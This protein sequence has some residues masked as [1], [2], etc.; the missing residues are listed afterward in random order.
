M[1]RPS[2][3]DDRTCY[4]DPAS[5]EPVIGVSDFID[6]SFQPDLLGMDPRPHTRQSLFKWPGGKWYL[7]HQIIP[8][9]PRH[10]RKMVSPFL[11]AGHIELEMAADGVKVYGSDIYRPMVDLWHEIKLDP[12]GF[13]DELRDTLGG[14]PL[15]QERADRG[16]M[17][18][19]ELGKGASRREVSVALLA[20]T[21]L[22]FG[23][24]VG[25][26]KA[27]TPPYYAEGKRDW[28]INKFYDLR[29]RAFHI[30]NLIVS[31]AD[32]RFAL[33]IH[34]DL[35][36]YCDPPYITKSMLYGEKGEVHKAFDHAEFVRT[37]MARPGPWA[38]SYNDCEFVR[39]AF[40]GCRFVEVE[41]DYRI[42][43]QAGK[44]V[45]KTTELLILRDGE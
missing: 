11:G 26:K 34:G 4:I 1:S 37:M 15:D 16:V 8:H 32:Y 6:T 2:S 5:G 10:L 40:Q 29:I 38:V 7:R 14:Y 18:W 17:L 9:F 28:A 12:V 3:P 25:S 41:S 44:E 42:M 21:K 13:A 45:P 33:A 43:V 31:E 36:A 30:P 35:F 24:L 20:S 23:A 27:Q 19:H 22:G 39:D